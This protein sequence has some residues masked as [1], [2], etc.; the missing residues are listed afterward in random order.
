MSLV[1][2]WNDEKLTW[3]E[4]VSHFMSWLPASY[5]SRTVCQFSQN[6]NAMFILRNQQE[7]SQ[8]IYAHDSTQRYKKYKPQIL[9]LEHD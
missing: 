4:A 5:V 1:C 6:H 2:S 3:I 9:V 8:N 7:Y